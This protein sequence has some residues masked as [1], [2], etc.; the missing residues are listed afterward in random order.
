MIRLIWTLAVS[1][2]A[3]VSAHFGYLHLAA[4][5]A[6]V[7]TPNGAPSELSWLQRELEL[8]SSELRA[9]NAM[10]E[11]YW[12]G[13]AKMRVQL[14]AERR[15]A[16]VTGDPSACVAMEAQCKG[17]TGSFIQQVTVVLTPAQRQ[18][19][20]GLV[21]SCLPPPSR[22]EGVNVEQSPRR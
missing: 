9:V 22:T 4:T 17:S 8:T 12:P 13:V 21:G 19:Y 2:L 20:L 16:Q 11:E 14:E 15:N 5:P 7:G 18:K 1:A 6:R 3:A 10:H